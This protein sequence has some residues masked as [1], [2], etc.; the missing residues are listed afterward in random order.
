MLLTLA[1]TFGL[2]RWNEH[3]ATQLFTEVNQLVQKGQDTEE[4]SYGESFEHYKAALENAQTI[5]RDYPSTSPAAR[6]LQ[7][8]KLGTYTLRELQE[9]IVPDMQQKAALEGD[10]LAVARFL[11][12]K[13]NDINK[14]HAAGG[15][16]GHYVEAGRCDEA[17][18][19]IET[20]NSAE[21][22]K[23]A[24][25]RL[26]ASHVE[27]GRLQQARDVAG[28]IPDPDLKV[29]ALLDM[30]RSPLLRDSWTKPDKLLAKPQSWPIRYSMLKG[31]STR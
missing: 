18:E 9:T 31:S 8:P 12:N 30:P 14:D 20:I 3:K 28:T 11:L 6:L 5:L 27:A 2:A 1:G 15:L 4:T 25:R 23:A 24:L 26:V 29:S 13:L 7:D 22:K 19:L 16:A 17:M 21:Y 10:P